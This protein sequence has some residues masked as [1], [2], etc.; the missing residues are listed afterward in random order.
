[1][2]PS[3]AGHASFAFRGEREREIEAKMLPG[4]NPIGRRGGDQLPIVAACQWT[5][6]VAIL[7]WTTKLIFRQE[8]AASG[9]VLGQ[10]QDKT[11]QTRLNEGLQLEARIQ[12]RHFICGQILSHLLQQFGLAGCFRR[13]FQ[14]HSN[15]IC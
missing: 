1:M 7:I 15:Q 6:D 13:V 5:H 2:I 11:L 8:I 14:I 4:F 3:E 9:E 12:D 10:A